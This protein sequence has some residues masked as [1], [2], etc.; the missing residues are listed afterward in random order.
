M[1]LLFDLAEDAKDGAPPEHLVMECLAVTVAATGL[2]Y[3]MRGL[4][5]ARRAARQDQASAEE[6]AR[7][8]R[9]SEGDAKNEATRARADALRSSTEAADA[10]EAALSAA[11]AAEAARREA[12]SLT[13]QLA[14]AERLRLEADSFRLSTKEATLAIAQAITDQLVTWGLSGAEMEVARLL[15]LGLSHRE[16]GQIRGTTE[17]TA[18]DQAQGVYKKAG[19]AGR[20][21]LAAFFLEDLLPIAPA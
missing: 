21:E 20:A 7:R 5:A 2:G 11:A 19:V 3:A 1:P 16:I 12:E 15:L 17:H 13:E 4:A 10:R 18:R 14:R 9:R 6:D 8:A